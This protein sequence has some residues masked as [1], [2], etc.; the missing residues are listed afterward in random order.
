MRAYILLDRSGSM[1][2]KWAE[3]LSAINGYVA[4]LAHATPALAVTL[5]T[6]DDPGPETSGPYEASAEVPW[7]DVI[8][9]AIP[10]EAWRPVIAEEIRPRGT[11]P[12]FDAIERLVSLAEDADADRVAIIVMTDGYENASRVATKTSARRRL[13]RCRERGWQ[14]VFLGADFDT[15][16][17]AADLG[18][19]ADQAL[20]MRTGHY[21]ASMAFV[22]H[23]TAAY[24]TSGTAMTFTE[25]EH[26]SG[27]I[28][29]LDDQD[30]REPRQQ[31]GMAML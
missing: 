14:V 15:M 22:A 16:A 3:A 12:L 10:A 13:D 4:E 7:F 18:A 9:T 28:Q 25:K 29:K 24:A 31:S 23:S 26:T 19:R 27:Q 8:R 5:A 30:A 21:S 1:T 2:G 20:N 6:F 17:Q 11:T